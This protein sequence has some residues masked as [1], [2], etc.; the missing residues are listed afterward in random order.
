VRSTDA[1]AS[2]LGGR[3]QRLMRLIELLLLLLLLL[4]RRDRVAR[5]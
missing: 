4:M 3:G 5:G 1:C 2:E